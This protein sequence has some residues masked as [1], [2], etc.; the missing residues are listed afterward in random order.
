[1]TTD[2]KLVRDRIPE[3]IERN[4]GTCEVRVLDDA[5]YAARLD[6][7]LAEELAEYLDSGGVEELADLV[8]V[9]R[10]ILVHRGMTWEALEALGEAKRPRTS[11]SGHDRGSIPASPLGDGLATWRRGGRP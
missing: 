6:A 8:E 9:I 1:M 4:G 2:D 10:A 7:K 3:I 11:R 5:E